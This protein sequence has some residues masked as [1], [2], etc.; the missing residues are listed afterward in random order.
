MVV[1]AIKTVR[2]SCEPTKE[3]LD[4]METF[5]LMVNRCIQIG[6][7][8]NI[9]SL[10]ALSSK[11]YRQLTAFKT[12]S[13]Y[14]LCAIS[15][16][17]G[18]LRNFRKALRRG[19][20]VR[21]PFAKQPMLTTC[22]G[23]K[24]LD[25]RL[26]L[27]LGNQQFV[28]IPLNQHTQEVL[29]DP[30]LTVRS[31]CLIARTVSISF[32]KEIAE[33]E[34]A[35]LIGMD[36]N[37]DNVSTASSD[38]SIRAYDLS[39]ATEIKAKYRAI[40]THLKRNDARVRKQVFGK[41]GRKQRNRIT[42]LLHLTSK[43]IVRQAKANQFGIVME[44]LTGIRRL[45]QRGNGQGRNYRFR[46]NSWS[47]AELQRQVEYKAKWEGIRVI[48]VS[49]QKTSSTCA[50]CGSH[51]TECTERRVWCPKCRTLVDRDVNASR[52]ILGRGMRFVPI[53][54]PSEA[55]VEEPPMAQSSKSMG[56][57]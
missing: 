43:D 4:L 14:K 42:Q 20:K 39:K 16:S 55:M 36:R 1:R 30:S 13:Y 23:F 41:Y 26:R 10:R 31:I 46:L 2:Q 48:Y 3:M 25:C 28:W 37:L 18:I 27:P 49:P 7:E 56:V 32:S 19:R 45:Y 40:K 17:V 22:Y 8:N 21:I 15:H 53:A 52:N 57:S 11:S 29:S 6:L 12:P 54:P 35:G 47:Y 5:R 38:G 9:T 44:K 50:I 51:A 24:I 33:V 34:P